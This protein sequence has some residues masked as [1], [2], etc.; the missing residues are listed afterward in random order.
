MLPD[1]QRALAATDSAEVKTRLE[2]LINR[3]GTHSP[4]QWATTRGIEALELMGTNPAARQLLRELAE[5]PVESYLGREARAAY[6][7]LS[8]K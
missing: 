3:L 4:G 8:P 6:R 1:L 2:R 7:R 5:T